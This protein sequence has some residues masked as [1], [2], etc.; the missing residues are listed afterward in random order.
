M[1][2]TRIDLPGAPAEVLKLVQA[3]DAMLRERA[4]N[5]QGLKYA[6]EWTA[7]GLA[8]LTER[9]RLTVRLGGDE[10]S[11]PI[12]RTE[13]TDPRDTRDAIRAAMRV[14]LRESSHRNTRELL[15]LVEEIRAANAA[16]LETV[17]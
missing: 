2:E 1:I 13:L 10:F 6:G 16:E 7:D 5:T 17:G 4:E 12:S 9:V 11:R 3:A 14:L 8:P 15:R